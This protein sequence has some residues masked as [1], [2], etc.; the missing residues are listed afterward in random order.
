MTRTQNRASRAAIKV[1]AA[2]SGAAA[3]SIIAALL[4]GCAATPADKVPFKDVPA[5]RIVKQAEAAL[6][7]L[8]FL[9]VRVRHHGSLARVEIA[10]RL[11]SVYP[12]RGSSDGGR[13]SITSS[14]SFAGGGN[15]STWIKSYTDD[16]DLLVEQIPFEETQMYLRIVY[17]NYWHYRALY[18]P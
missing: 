15:V 14:D 11:G 7:G 13:S 6:H 2:A 18:R 4:S 1:M 9:Q 16:P 12:P 3:A 8:G 5:D 10:R 17:D